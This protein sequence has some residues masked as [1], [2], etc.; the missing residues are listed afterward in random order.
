[1]KRKALLIGMPGEKKP[2]SIYNAVNNDLKDFKEYLMS[3]AGGEWEDGDE[4]MIDLINPGSFGVL[5]NVTSINADYSLIYFSGH[6]GEYRSRKQ[7]IELSDGEFEIVNLKTKCPKQLIIIDSCRSILDEETKGFIKKAMK[8]EH[9]ENFTFVENS[10]FIFNKHLENCENGIILL[11]AASFESPAGC[12]Q[13]ES[14]Y[15]SSLIMA[16]YE[17]HNNLGGEEQDQILDVFDAVDKAQSI[18][19]D[20][21]PTNQVAECIGGK[22]KRFFP[23]SV[24]NTIL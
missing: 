7:I 2:G 4:I 17:W 23:F 24:R 14:F 8:E 5:G 1:M 9:E 15:T 6:G 19:M 11:N 13:T 22:R 12:N 10:K 18:M 16:G 3:N 21:F 20:N